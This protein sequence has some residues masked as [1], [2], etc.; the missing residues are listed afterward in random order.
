MEG[1]RGVGYRD[2]KGGSSRGVGGNVLDGTDWTVPAVTPA[3]P[4]TPDPPS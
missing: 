4:V 2:L 3:A 1:R